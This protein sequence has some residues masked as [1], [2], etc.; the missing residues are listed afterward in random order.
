[1]MC[2]FVG[3]VV[4][5]IH[6]FLLDF[7]VSMPINY[8]DLSSS[9]PS[10]HPLNVLIVGPLQKLKLFKKENSFFS[11]GIFNEN[12]LNSIERLSSLLC[13]NN[14]RGSSLETFIPL[15]NNLFQRIALCAIPTGQKFLSL[16]CFDILIIC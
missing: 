10:F 7:F 11:Q 12:A 6:F 14:E 15:E 13:P 16:S 3:D 1:M 4:L 9:F 5:K 8:Y 2:V